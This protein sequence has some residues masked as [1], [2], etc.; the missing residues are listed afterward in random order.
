MVR[1]VFQVL[2]QAETSLYFCLQIGKRKET[3]ERK[4]CMSISFHGSLGRE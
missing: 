1:P 2:L 4:Q 3:K